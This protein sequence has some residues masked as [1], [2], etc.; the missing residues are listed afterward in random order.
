MKKQG[1]KFSVIVF[2]MLMYTSFICSTTT[3]FPTLAIVN[4]EDV[5]FERCEINAV[6]HETLVET[7]VSGTFYN[8]LNTSTTGVFHITI[9]SGSYVSNISLQTHNLTYWGRIMEKQEAVE[10]FENATEANR[11]AVL[12]TQW[13]KYTFIVDFSI[14]PESRIVV[15]LTYFYL[16]SA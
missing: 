10:A 4:Q 16:I 7:N 14:E 8:P 11:T 3:I 12:L 13:G 15:K 5:I 9:P 6:I 1:S 2:V